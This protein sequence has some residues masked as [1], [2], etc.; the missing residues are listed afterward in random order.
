MA[1]RT[2]LQRKFAKLPLAKNAYH[3]VGR[4]MTTTMSHRASKVVVTQT[5]VKQAAGF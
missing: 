5:V 1:A 3:H 4:T 2:M